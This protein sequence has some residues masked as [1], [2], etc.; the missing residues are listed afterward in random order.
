MDESAFRK[1]FPEF[2][3][4]EKYPKTTVDLWADLGEELFGRERWGRKWETGVF[5]FVAHNL[6]LAR[7]N[8]I[9]SAAGG[10]PGSVSGTVTSKSVGSVSVSYNTSSAQ[11]TKAGAWNQTTY[12]QQL[13]QLIRLVG[14]GVLI[15]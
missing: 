4:P 14:Q 13:F 6:V 15:A 11:D 12:G 5:L 7:G 10:V 8:A 1:R 3:D 9:A 2:A